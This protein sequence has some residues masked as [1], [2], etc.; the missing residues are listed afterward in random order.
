MGKIYAR[1]SGGRVWTPLKEDILDCLEN[2]LKQGLYFL[3]MERKSSLEDAAIQ[4]SREQHPPLGNNWMPFASNL[5]FSTDYS[6]SSRITSPDGKEA[7]LIV[8]LSDDYV[9]DP[10]KTG[11]DV[12]RISFLVPNMLKLMDQ[13]DYFMFDGRYEEVSE[14]IL[15]RG[16]KFVEP[17]PGEFITQWV[18]RI[19]R[20]VLEQRK[21]LITEEFVDKVNMEYFKLAR[22]LTR[23]ELIKLL[24][25]VDV[26]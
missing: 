10:R 7:H 9:I 1:K 8:Q 5:G 6:L 2:P 11:R 16:Y 15:R 25:N 17:Q 21:R 22:K 12:R 26:T 3:Q 13:G 18:L 14:A 24:R 19:K 20:E 23:E 4:H